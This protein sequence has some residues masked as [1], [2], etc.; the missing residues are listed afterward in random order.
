M[1][2]GAAPAAV[3]EHVDADAVDAADADAMEHNIFDGLYTFP[4][5]VDN[6]DD[7]KAGNLLDL[8]L[9]RYKRAVPLRMM[10][11]SSAQPNKIVYLDPLQK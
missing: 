5:E 6:E 10:I 8:E 2:D 7:D 1:N 3:V 11:R 4:A 9:K